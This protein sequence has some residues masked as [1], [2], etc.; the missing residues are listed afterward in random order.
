MRV[1]LLT[2]CLCV[3]GLAGLRAEQY[4]VSGYVSDRATGESL[5]S[6]SVFDLA[7]GKGMVTNPYGFYSLTLPEGAVRLRYSYVGYAP[8]VVE[9]RLERDTVINIRLGEDNLLQEVTVTGHNADLGLQGAQMSAVEVPVAQ[10][11]AVP[12]L[13]GETDVVKALQL[14]PGVQ[15]GTEGS[16]GFYVRGGGPDENLF[17]LDGVPVYNIN[18]LGGFFS[19]FNGDA[20]KNVTLYKGGFPA[21]FGGRL[22]SVLDVRMKD[23]NNQRLAGSVSVGLI[24]AKLNLEGPLFSPNTTFNISARRTYFDVLA[25]PVLWVMKK[26]EDY[27]RLSA[28]YYFYDLNAKVSHRFSDRDRLYLSFYMGDDAVYTRMKDEWGSST[29]E[30]RV[31]WGWGNLVG[32]LRWNH[33][34]GNKLFMNATATYTQYRFNMDNRYREESPGSGYLYE[35]SAGYRSGI[36]D[37]TAKA[38]F[39]Y[40]LASSHSLKFGAGYTAHL[41]RPGVSA[42]RMEENAGDGLPGDRLETETGDENVFAH[43]AFAYVE[44]N[45][46]IGHLLKANAGLHYSAF[47]VQGKLYHSLQPRLSA[48]LLI[49]DD[50]SFKAGYAYMNQ[51]VHLLSNNGI[52]L[53]TDLW[54]PVTR[55]IEPMKAHQVSAGFFYNLLDLLD[56]SVEAY[57]KPMDNLIE[58]KDGA[59]FL[60]T[61]TGWEDKVSVGRG[62]AYGVELLVQKSVGNTTGW[63]GYTWSKSDRLFDRPGQEL[64]FGRVFPAKYDRRHDVSVVVSHKFSERFDISGT[65][66]FSTGNAATLNMQTYDPLPGFVDDNGEIGYE[67]DV[68]YIAQRNNFRYPAYH[69]LDLGVNFHKK[70]KRGTRTWNISVYNAYNSMNPFLIYPDTDPQGRPVLTKLTLFPIIPSVSYT[71]K[72]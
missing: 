28:G 58:Y 40:A 4:T 1:F 63:V 65:W 34:F 10:L 32:A 56:L 14:M 2:F 46:S 69:R 42:A 43:E 11:K 29:D 3:A 38:D 51:Y 16:A 35:A 71:F 45:F 21:R 54:V 67:S 60:A 72:W 30:M 59:S 6:A 18:H 15:D 47:V 27:D 23:G 50:L 24:S 55:R 61:G 17:L 9:L 39:D 13:L 5:I 22:S 44:D 53:P 41:F 49:T 7:S 64:N 25:Q 57:Y 66:V 33:V 48:R 62:W 52:N 37:W 68:P 12:A 31:D 20:V 70:K 19:V 26:Q 8:Q 36:H